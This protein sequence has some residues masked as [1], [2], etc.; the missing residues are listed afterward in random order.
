MKLN[1]SRR[2]FFVLSSLC[3]A[4]L[5][6]GV[7]DVALAAGP[8]D[9]DGRPLIKKLGT[10][11]VDIV[12]TTPV[13][14]LGKVYRFEWYRNGKCMRFREHGTNRPT[15]SF[16]EGY[17]F[18]SAFVDGD[19]VYVTA[20]DSRE[21]EIHGRIQMFASKDLEHWES[22]TA[23]QLQGYGFFNTSICKAD[24]KY[25]MMFE[26]D[27]PKEE[28]GVAFTA[29][30]AV[31]KDLKTW[32]LTPPECNYAKDR[33]TAPHTLRYLDGY[34][35][36]FY[37]EAL[38]GSFEMRVVRSPDLIHWTPSPLNP[39]LRVSDDDRTVLN[40]QLDEKTRQRIATAPNCNSSDID[41]C[42]FE[43]RLVINYSWGNQTG[44]EHLAE[45]VYEGSLR[46]FLTGWFPADKQAKEDSAA[47]LKKLRQ[48]RLETLEKIGPV[49][50]L[51]YQL[52]SI[53]FNAWQSAHLALLKAR[54]EM[55][56]NKADRIRI[57]EKTVKAA[58]DL[59]DFTRQRSAAGYRT[60][61][62]ESLQAEAFLLECQ[63]NLEQEKAA[64]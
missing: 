58:E 44:I 41:F 40:Q 35:Y 43:G 6:W 16:G 13:V 8:V 51:Q 7:A 5:V 38:P 2:L 34:Y 55:C 33:Y 4:S 30:F 20:S 23:L 56:Q 24:D 9:A 52:G 63:I 22:W 60:S 29:R 49:V 27:R 36:N 26:I 3:L 15:K 53:D 61:K 21:R 32:T 62:L 59:S 11:D 14:F 57:R 25:V 19:T 48:Q 42:E 64:N 28:A 39:V 17:R 1:H 54:L 45:A 47:R 10:V 37:L 31:S 46:D 50:T 12:E 18:G